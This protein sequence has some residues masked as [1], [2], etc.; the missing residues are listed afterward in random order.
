MKGEYPIQQQVIEQ[1]VVNHP[2][3]DEWLNVP[4]FVW[5]GVIV[6]I[7]IAWIAHRKYRK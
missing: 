5:L 6:P 1:P 2:E 3:P 7:I 4:D